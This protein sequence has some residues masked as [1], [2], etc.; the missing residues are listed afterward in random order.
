LSDNLKFTTGAF[1]N[2][3]NGTNYNSGMQFP[4]PY[5]NYNQAVKHHFLIRAEELIAAGMTTDAITSLAFNVAQ[6]NSGAT[7]ENFTISLKHTNT[8]SLS[9]PWDLNNWTLVY[10]P[11]NYVP[12]L[13]WNIHEFDNIF[14]WDGVSNILVGVCFYNSSPVTLNESFYYTSTSYFSAKY[15]GGSGGSTIC[16]SPARST[17]STNRPNMM[18]GLDIPVIL[19]PELLLPLNTAIDVSLTP[20]LE[21]AESENATSYTLQV[22]D[23][24]NFSTILIEHIITE[25]TSYQVTPEEQ[26]N[27]ST[28][29]FWRLNA[30]NEDAISDWS[31]VFSFTTGSASETQ[32]I[33]LNSGWNIISSYIQPENSNVANIFENIVSNVKIVKNG[34]GEMYDPAFNI[35]TIGN[36]NYSDGYL[37][38]M[39][40]NNELTITGTKLLPEDTP[41]NL[42]N[43]WNLSA[44]LRVN[45]MSAITALTSISSSLVLAKDNVGGIYMPSFGINTLGNMLAGQGYY[46]YMG[47]AAELTYP[48]N[49]A[50][51]AVAGN[52]ITPL[53]KFLIPSMNNTGK[54]STLII[55]IENNEENEIGVY[56]MNNELIGSGAVHN[57][58]AAITVWGDDDATQNIDGAKDNEYLNVKLYNTSDNTNKE[59]SL[60]QIREITGNTEQ[61]ELYYKTNAIFVAKASANDESGF[62]MSIKNIPNPVENDVV[63]EFGLTEEANAEIQIYTSTGELVASIGKGNYSAGIHRIN[64]DASNLASG[65]YN[66]VLSSGSKKVSSFM[67]VDK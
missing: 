56:N 59:I 24:E 8:T 58:I 7:L 25:G 10:G 64:F 32:N 63:F 27:T 29:Y 54:N 21:W 51:K 52:N 57:G 16:S 5:G 50:Q 2:I 40:N 3:G 28:Q 47:A 45:E 26:L 14:N 33:S 43:G 4:A 67:I 30:A 6:I 36:W 65:M 44:Y 37:V 12:N 20:V 13:G 9:N 19:P 55:S 66:I 11:Y 49:S 39:L 22:S 35:N 61:S 48:S 31:V 46:F 60:S 53:A 42:N 62:G 17:L 15:Y 34:A 1:V 41:I 38:N 18:F 23:N